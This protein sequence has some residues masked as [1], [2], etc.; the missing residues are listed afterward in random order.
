[1]RALKNVVTLAFVLFTVGAAGCHRN[2]C[3]PICEQREKELNCHP[4][5]SCKATCEQL[6][7]AT[8]CAKELKVFE[9]CFLAETPKHW[10]CDESGL[11]VVQIQFCSKE[12]NAVSTC[13]ENT[14]TTPQTATPTA[15]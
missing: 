12:R 13:L 14:P 4:Q 9:D 6:H 5:E 3:V 8:T 15:H 1:V 11:P 10:T 7:T 2:R